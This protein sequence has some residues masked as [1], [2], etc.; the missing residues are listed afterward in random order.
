MKNSRI[1]VSMGLL[2]AV[3]NVVF[4]V[5]FAKAIGLKGIALATSCVHLTVA[6]VF[7]FRLEAHLRT[8]R[9]DGSR[10]SQVPA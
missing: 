3:L 6:I 9:D 1:M 2:N 4:D 5:L 7:W 10:T 8:V